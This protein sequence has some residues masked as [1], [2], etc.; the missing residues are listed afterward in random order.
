MDSASSPPANVN[1]DFDQEAYCK[2]WTDSGVADSCKVCY[3]PDIPS[4]LPEGETGSSF[5][6]KLNAIDSSCVSN[7]LI[8]VSPSLINF[9]LLLLCSCVNGGRS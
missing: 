7:A 5:N 6:D 3:I 2:K 1:K 9:L 8:V 4:V